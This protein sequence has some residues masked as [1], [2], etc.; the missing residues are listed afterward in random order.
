MKVLVTGGAGFIGSNLVF[1]LLARGDEVAVVDDLSTGSPAN[2]HPAAA[3]RK[4]DILDPALPALVAGLLPDAVVHLAAQASV[5]AS[6]KDPERDEQV[7]V[8]GTRAVARAAREAGARRMLSASS[9]AVYGAPEV[10]P[11]P[12]DA[13][14]APDNPYGRSKLAAETALIE[15][16][17]GSGTDFASLRF[18]NVYGPRQ[19]WRGEGGV[20]AIFAAR[21]AAGETPIVNGDGTQTRDYIYVGDIVGAILAA[22][23]TEDALG[24][25]TGDGPAY[26]VSTGAQTNVLELVGLLRPLTGYMGAVAHGPLPEGDI[27]RSA[28]DPGK[29]ASAIGW[30]AGVGLERGLPPT[31]RWFAANR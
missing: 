6:V 11:V 5:A 26:N 30:R 16:L 13:P 21:M 25:G 22:L 18:A 2:L 27:P 19:D 4:M 20:V 31:V 7:N 9:A 23:D 8:G 28:L 15:E 24:C 1:A 29:L 14:K 10:I 3:F 12:E 17:D